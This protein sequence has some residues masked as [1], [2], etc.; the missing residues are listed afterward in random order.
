MNAPAADVPAGTSRGEH[1]KLDRARGCLIGQIAGDSLGSLVEFQSPED[2]GRLYPDGVRDL[3][4]GGTFDTL[5]GQPT[6]DSEMALALARTLIARGTYD[7]Q[8]ANR[9]Y[10]DWLDS[11]PFDCGFTIR[12]GLLGKPR[13]ES[14]ANGALMRVGPLGI[15]GARHRLDTVARWA[16]EDARLTHPNRVCLDANAL[17]AMAI[18]YAI[19][20]GPAPRE[21]YERIA[22]WANE[23][24]ISPAVR[25]CV[26]EAAVGLPEDYMTHMGWVLIA[27]RNALWQLRHAASLEAGV[28]DS[29]M[30]GGDTDTNAAICG[31]LLGA[32][33]GLEAVP[34]RWT[35]AI[36]RCRPEAGRP[37][38]RRPRPKTYWP[39]DAP[40][41]ATQLLRPEPPAS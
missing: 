33:H 34:A 30:R 2:I 22:V 7:P 8:A 38:V 12:D 40:E 39:I 1:P 24:E 18:A 4:D 23:E 27:L 21:L 31:A 20:R 37:R 13:R 32:V 35:G 14:Q 3:E 6:D 28:I 36:L 9:A 29:V 41:L 11:D 16:R 5:A 17:F 19:D 10:T 15:F 26:D 25:A